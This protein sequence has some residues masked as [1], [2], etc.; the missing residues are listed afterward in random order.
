[1]GAMRCY[2]KKKKTREDQM[3]EMI[4][5]LNIPSDP[6]LAP[7]EARCPGRSVKDILSEENS[8]HDDG[9]MADSYKFLGN[10]DLSFSRYTDQEFYDQEIKKVWSFS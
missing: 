10:E 2:Y 6:S 8:R 9:L 3:K 4:E 7:G 1:M 5:E